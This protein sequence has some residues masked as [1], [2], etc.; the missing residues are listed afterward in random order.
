MNKRTSRIDVR[1]TQKERI[2]LQKLANKQGVSMSDWFR[3]K[4]TEES[5]PQSNLLG[6]TYFQDARN[7]WARWFDL[8]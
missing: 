1:L 7:A 2:A 8:K 6:E 5:E 4:I 3:G